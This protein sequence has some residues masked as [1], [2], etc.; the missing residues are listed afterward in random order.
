MQWGKLHRRC[1]K[2]QRGLWFPALVARGQLGDEAQPLGHHA[3]HERGRH[4]ERLLEHEGAMVDRADADPFVSGDLLMGP[5]C[6]QAQEHGPQLRREY[7][8]LGAPRLPPA[9]RYLDRLDHPLTAHIHL[10]RADGRKDVP[11]ALGGH[12][13]PLEEGGHV[14]CGELAVGLGVQQLAEHDDPAGRAGRAEVAHERHEPQACQVGGE[15]NEVGVFLRRDAQGGLALL[16]VV[17]DAHLRP[18]REGS[19]QAHPIEVAGRDK[20]SGGGQHRCGGLR[21]RG[22]LQVHGA[23]LSWE[24]GA[25]RLGSRQERGGLPR[26][27]LLLIKMQRGAEIR[28]GG[29]SKIRLS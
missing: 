23:N 11:E 9:L 4:V 25:L 7:G 28:H 27:S 17:D 13:L 20:Q 24:R 1:R 14:E 10:A 22:G 18:I 5:G 3:E 8:T 29:A 6:R 26:C 12:N 19:A 16:H 2:P 15:E 21:V